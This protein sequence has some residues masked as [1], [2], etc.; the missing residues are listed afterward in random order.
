MS[1]IDYKTAY[2]ALRTKYTD[3]CDELEL[4]K[5]HEEGDVVKIG[6]RRE[7]KIWRQKQAL[8]ELNRRV[9]VQRLQLRRLNE[10]E[11]GLRPDEWKALKEE[12]AHE[13][14]EDSWDITD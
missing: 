8:R 12:F 7:S 13:L 3:V 2:G 4:L 11:R 14:A 1:E 10:L 5:A 6:Y 9:R